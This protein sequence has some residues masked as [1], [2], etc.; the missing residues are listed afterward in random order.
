MLFLIT[1][2]Y[3]S[4]PRRY[5]AY[6]TELGTF[7]I[8]PV[9]MLL[10]AI[11]SMIGNLEHLSYLMVFVDFIMVMAMLVYG[12]ICL[13]NLRWPSIGYWFYL[14]LGALVLNNRL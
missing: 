8:I 5:K 13:R 4:G 9:A 11:P 3:L 10:A 14:A 7:H 12:L 6:D 2:I 1:T